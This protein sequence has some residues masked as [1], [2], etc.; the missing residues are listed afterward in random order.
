M[1]DIVGCDSPANEDILVK[2]TKPANLRM[3]V[4]DWQCVVRA[5]I[6][7]PDALAALARLES[8]YKYNAAVVEKQTNYDN[9]NDTAS[10]VSD[11]NVSNSNENDDFQ[12]DTKYALNI[13]KYIGGYL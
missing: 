9:A 8:T 11:N 4:E 5:S 3:S 2:F 7:S 12:L 1:T 13:N 10:S 6:D